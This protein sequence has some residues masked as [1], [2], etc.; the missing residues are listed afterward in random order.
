MQKVSSPWYFPILLLLGSLILAALSF[1]SCGT[2]TAHPTVRCS[3]NQ[4]CPAS[5]TNRTPLVALN[6]TQTATQEVPIVE[7]PTSKTP[8]LAYLILANSDSQDSGHTITDGSHLH[9]ELIPQEKKIGTK[10]SHVLSFNRISGE[11]D[12]GLKQIPPATYTMQ[13]SGT[14]SEGKPL[15]I[16]ASY[17][18]DEP[19]HTQLLALQNG[20]LG[21]QGQSAT[22][23]QVMMCPT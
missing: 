7:T 23:V 20:F 8:T 11:D 9:I 12:I 5:S 13:I 3:T 15:N 22:T 19:A 2:P 21:T 17:N 14:D 18:D 6:A 16:C 4:H 10:M 1:S